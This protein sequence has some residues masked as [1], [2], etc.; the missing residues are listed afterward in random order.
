MLMQAADADL[1]RKDRVH[2][3]HYTTRRSRHQAGHEAVVAHLIT[4]IDIVAAVEV[5]S[6]H[7]MIGHTGP[8]VNAAGE[9]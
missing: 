9:R 1:Q 6:A 7:V 4:V 5:V 3:K 8:V 2:P